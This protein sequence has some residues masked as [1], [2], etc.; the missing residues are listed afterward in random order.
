MLNSP[1]NI[2]T[3]Q[4]KATHYPLHMTLFE[5]FWYKNFITGITIFC[6]QK[7]LIVS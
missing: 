3:L 5:N 4:P 6:L 7:R 2:K 1:L